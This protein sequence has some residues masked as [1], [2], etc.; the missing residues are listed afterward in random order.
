MYRFM[1]ARYLEPPGQYHPGDI[2]VVFCT[3]R[4]HSPPP[5]PT[6]PYRPRQ[7]FEFDASSRFFAHLQR[8]P[9]IFCGLGA[10][11]PQRGIDQERGQTSGDIV[12]GISSRGQCP[13]T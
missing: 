7:T 9:H 6:P 2:A 12:R 13:R 3:A 1:E 10:I 8:Y 5:P 4:H 11:N